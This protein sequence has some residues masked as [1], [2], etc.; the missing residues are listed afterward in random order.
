MCEWKSVCVC[1]CALAQR[2]C[3]ALCYNEGL[4][5]LLFLLCARA[6]TYTT[7]TVEANRVILPGRRPS[8][9]ENNFVQSSSLQQ[10]KRNCT[11]LHNNLLNN[12]GFTRALRPKKALTHTQTLYAQL[13]VKVP[14]CVPK[15]TSR[16]CNAAGIAE[17]SKLNT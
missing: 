2:A 10:A 12:R 8:A 9:E 17:R 3:N 1:A 11:N 5:V 6:R 16:C 14:A 4:L 15:I 7:R 13:A